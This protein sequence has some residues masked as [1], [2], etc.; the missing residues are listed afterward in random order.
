M[1]TNSMLDSN[2]LLALLSRDNP[3]LNCTTFSQENTSP[4]VPVDDD[5]SDED[6]DRVHDEGEEQVLSDEGQHQGGGRQNL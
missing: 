5:D 3:E 1:R 4:E 6:R 2:L